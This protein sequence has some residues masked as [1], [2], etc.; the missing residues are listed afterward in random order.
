MD[1]LRNFSFQNCLESS[2]AM[3][4]EL[5]LHCAI[6]FRQQCDSCPLAL[7]MREILVRFPL[8]TTALN[9]TRLKLRT[10]AR[11]D[12][13]RPISKTTSLG[14]SR[15][16]GHGRGEEGSR[17]VKRYLNRGIEDREGLNDLFRLGCSDGRIF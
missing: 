7:I 11:D 5:E 8:V 9:T 16:D 13:C 2:D 10:S 17:R 4:V 3:V 14:M 1:M 12:I 15:I 6:Q